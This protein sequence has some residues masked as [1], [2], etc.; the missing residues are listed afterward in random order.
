[1]LTAADF[2][3]RHEEN[4]AAFPRG[5]WTAGD[6]TNAAIGQGEVAVTPLQ[7][8][9]SYAALANGGTVFAPNI[10]QNV[11]PNDENSNAIEFGPR[12]L[13][14]AEIPDS[15]E[16]EILDGLLGVTSLPKLNIEQPSGTGWDAFNN[17]FEEGLDGA[18]VDLVNWPVAGKT[19]TAEVLGRADNSMFVGFGP[20]GSASFGTAVKTPEYVVAVVLEEAGF[21][22]QI[23]APMVARIFDQIARDD[24]PRA[25]TQT[26]VDDFYSVEDNVD[27]VLPEEDDDF[28]VENAGGA[29]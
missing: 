7:L 26:E 3:A 9:N 14:E 13:R 6:A 28:V 12:V 22:S 19:G 2:E 24:V 20:S 16:G 21:G 5:Q 1:M 15:I 29:G 11:I 17:P 10:V 25:A 4:P 18:I 27:G 8:A 23:A